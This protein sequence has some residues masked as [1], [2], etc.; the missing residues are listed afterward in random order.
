MQQ[1]YVSIIIPTYKDWARLALCVKAL[2]Q[3]T[4]P[5]ELFEVVIVNNNPNDRV[6]ENF[7]LPGNCTIIAEKKTGSYAAR[8][9]ALQ[10]AKGEIIAFTDSDC[11][12]DKDWIRNAVAYLRGHESCSRIA[13]HIA[14]F[15][16]SPRATLGDKYEMLYAFPQEMYTQKYKAGVT[17]NMFTYRKVFDAVGP[18]NEKLFSAGDLAWGKAAHLAGYPVHYVENVVVKHPARSLK[19]LI[20]KEKRVGGGTGMAAR[21][22]AV[23]FSYLINLIN[24]FR[25]RISEIKYVYK[26]QDKGL[27]VIDKIK[28][29]F[30]RHYLLNV[31]AFEKLRV[32][33][34]KEPNRA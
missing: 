14:I 1:G 20:K 2:A 24:G 25:P 3:Q 23:L 27:N 17:G 26:Q 22:K 31:R 8:N 5:V 12:P 6:P 19:E 11:I 21:E 15:S 7:W 4:Y 16:D 9:A 32:H 29:L 34:G 18:F 13:G 10:I 30:L 33:M 28:V